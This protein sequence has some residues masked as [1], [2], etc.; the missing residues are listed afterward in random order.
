M[1]GGLGF[2]VSGLDAGLDATLP[3]ALTHSRDS[4]SQRAFRLGNS[5]FL[6]GPE[7]TAFEAFRLAVDLKGSWA[8]NKFNAARA[9]IIQRWRSGNKGDPLQALQTRR[10]FV[11]EDNQQNVYSC[12]AAFL[13]L[14]FVW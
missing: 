9:S 13:A 10:I 2:R 5:L 11:T 14:L 6:F 1:Y 4:Y 12:S 8:P 3:M 7:D